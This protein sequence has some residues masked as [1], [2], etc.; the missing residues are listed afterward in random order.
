MARIVNHSY[1]SA[2]TLLDHIWPDYKVKGKQQTKDKLVVLLTP[3]TSS[4]ICPKCGKVCYKVHAKQLRTAKD[5]PLLGTQPLEIQIETRRYKCSCGCT[6]TQQLSFIS[7]RAKVTKSAVL[8]AQQLLRV[9]SLSISDVVKLTGLSWTTLKKLDKEQLKFCY[10]E[11]SFNGVQNIAIDEFSVHKNHKYATVVIDNDTC[12]VLWVG[13]GKSQKCVQPFFDLLKERGVAENIRSVACDQNAAYPALVRENLP[14]AS[15]V[16]DLFHVLANW[17][18]DVLFEAKKVTQAQVAARVRKEAL[19]QA[20]KDGLKPDAQMI[21]SAVKK[22]IAAF[23][24][25]DWALIAPLKPLKEKKRPDYK[26]QLEMIK[27]ENSLLADLYPLSEALRRLWKE[28]SFEAAQQS[29]RN[30]RLLLLEIGRKYQFKPATSF[31][32]MLLRRE[33]GILMAGRF[34]FATDRLEGVNNKIK[35]A[36]RIAYGFNDLEY[37][38]LKIK[39]LLPGKFTIPIFDKLKGVAIIKGAYWRPDWALPSPEEVL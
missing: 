38:F 16:Y 17:R 18:R 39:G 27:A 1:A 4:A 35:V 8:F 32:R 3:R 7:P 10:D 19:E 9:P 37:F 25:A 31:A 23:S 2:A 6:C 34:G 30:I 26:A 15:I 28:K 36:K 14:N 22:A 21:N 24:G 13:K 33:D 20:Q 5:A 11:I 29:I 12:R